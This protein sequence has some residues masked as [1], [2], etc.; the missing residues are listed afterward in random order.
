MRKALKIKILRHTTASRKDVF[1]GQTLTAPGD[2]SLEDARTLI[3]MKKAVEVLEIS[4]APGQGPQDASG[5]DVTAPD[6]LRTAMDRITA[7]L[8]ETVDIEADE[9]LEMAEDALESGA[10]G[11]ITAALEEL[12]ALE[13]KLAGTEG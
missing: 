5:P 4:D 13:K 7:L 1:A 12:L 3:A 9:A 2:I 11:D 6:A 10:L 8:G